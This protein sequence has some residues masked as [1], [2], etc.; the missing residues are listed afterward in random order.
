MIQSRRQDKKKTRNILELL[1][2]R[3]MHR[4]CGTPLSLTLFL[5]FLLFFFLSLSR[6]LF[7][8]SSCSLSPRSLHLL[9][10]SFG[11]CLSVSLSPLLHFLP[12]D[13]LSLAHLPSLLFSS[14]FLCFPLATGGSEGIRVVVG[15]CLCLE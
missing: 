4:H 10:L 12:N 3:I 13:S 15:D 11:P 8:F 5:S 7:L 9:A 2:F 14:P 6:L 1:C